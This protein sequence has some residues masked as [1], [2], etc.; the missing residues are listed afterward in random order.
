MTVQK[1]FIFKRVDNFLVLTQIKNENIG[2]MICDVNYVFV[3]S[4][5]FVRRHVKARLRNVDYCWF[6]KQHH[7]YL[8]DQTYII[9][10]GDTT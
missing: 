4:Q 1:T 10:Q 7:I 9:F 2:A 3:T 8:Y 5:C 6:V